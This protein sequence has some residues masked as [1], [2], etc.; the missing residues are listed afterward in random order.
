MP[1]HLVA[2]LLQ[3]LWLADNYIS[4]ITA[5][6][7]LCNLRELNLAR[8]DIAVMGSNFQLSSRLTSLNLA[9]NNISSLQVSF[10]CCKGMCLSVSFGALLGPHA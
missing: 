5:I 4:S 7:Q 2:D 6:S 3:V 9:D 10:S 8:N 1:V